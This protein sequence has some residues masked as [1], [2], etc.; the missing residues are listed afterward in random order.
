MIATL[1][2]ALAA[3][4]MRQILVDHM[5]H[6]TSLEWGIAGIAELEDQPI[7]LGSRAFGGSSD[8]QGNLS[9]NRT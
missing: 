3:G 7:P 4:V 1:F 2:F 5:R 8:V 9:T 6:R